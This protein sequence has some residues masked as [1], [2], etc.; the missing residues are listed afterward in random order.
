MAEV[1]GD[2]VAVL[3]AG[4]QAR[5]MGGGDKCL[6]PLGGRPLLAH[7]IARIGPQVGPMVL[8]AGGEPDRFADFGLPVIPDIVPGFAGPLAGILSGLEWVV[9]EVPDCRWVLSVPTDAPFLPHDLV[10][11]MVHDVLEAGEGALACGASAGRRHPVVG[12]WPLACR[13]PLRVALVENDVR[14]IDAFTADYACVA[15][16]YP[17]QPYDPF[18][19]ANR[20]EDLALAETFLG[21]AGLSPD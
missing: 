20:P 9:R 2:V 3:L 5:R 8:N 21:E 13:D 14:K 4:G 11:R 12:L 15:V 7:V 1:R 10:A 18:L 17:D 19:N 6:Q 16:E